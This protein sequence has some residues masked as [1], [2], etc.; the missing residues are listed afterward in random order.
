MYTTDEKIRL[1]SPLRKIVDVLQNFQN[2]GL[3]RI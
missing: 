2:R 1:I 3:E